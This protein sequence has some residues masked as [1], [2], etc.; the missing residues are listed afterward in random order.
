[1]ISLM[2]ASALPTITFYGENTSARIFSLN[3]DQ[4]T[5]Q[6]CMSVRK[7]Y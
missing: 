7:F 6:M 5:V 4:I 3:A 2:S 1:L